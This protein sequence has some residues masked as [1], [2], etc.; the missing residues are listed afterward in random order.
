MAVTAIAPTTG[1]M[2]API[3]TLLLDGAIAAGRAAPEPCA[4]TEE[5]GNPGKLET[6]P[7]EGVG[8]LENAIEVPVE[9]SDEEPVGATEVTEKI[10]EGVELD[11][12]DV[13]TMGGSDGGGDGC[14]LGC[15][16]VLTTRN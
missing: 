7:I 11:A 15:G 12:R 10:D 14:E 2:I 6:V 3:L 1:P 13:V 4:P 9:M 16:V 5:E 8:L